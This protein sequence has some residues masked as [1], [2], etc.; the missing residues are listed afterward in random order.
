MILN[1]SVNAALFGCD[2]CLKIVVGGALGWVICIGALVDND[3]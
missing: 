2:V 1:K 3:N